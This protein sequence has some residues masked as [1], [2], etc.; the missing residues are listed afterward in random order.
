M[1]GA[2]ILALA[3]LTLGIVG[4]GGPPREARLALEHTAGGLVTADELLADA[5]ERRGEE[6]R[7]QVRREVREG[8]FNEGCESTNDNTGET[9]VSRECVIEAGLARFEE[10]MEP[11]ST[12]RT[13]LRTTRDVLEAFELSMDAWEAGTGDEASFFGAAA[14]GLAALVEVGRA[15]IAAGIDVPDELAQGI[16]VLSGFASG[17]C[18]GGS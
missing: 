18:A 6:V 15:L 14:C 4:C 9:T 5:I 12:A 3:F 11:T 8:R 16:G 13:V 17:A 10:L 2:V 7:L 1:K